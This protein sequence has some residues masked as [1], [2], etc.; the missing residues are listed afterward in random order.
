MLSH[1]SRTRTAVCR[2]VRPRCHYS[3]LQK[4][5]RN[6]FLNSIHVKTF[7]DKEINDAFDKLKTSDEV[8]VTADIDKA[9]NEHTKSE[10]TREEIHLLS[11]KVMEDLEAK[12]KS[13]VVTRDSFGTGLRRLGSRFDSRVKPLVA[14]Y[15]V[16]GTTIGVIVPCMPLLVSELNISSPQ[17]GVIV[18]SFGL[19]KLLGNIPSSHYVD[20]VGRKPLFFSGLVLASFAIGGIGLS[21]NPL[22]GYPWIICCRVLTGLGVSAI[23]AGG[24]MMVADIST[25]LNRTQ[26]QAPLQSAWQMGM[27]AGPGVGGFLIDSFGLS[28]TY[29]SVG[30]SML[31]VTAVSQLFVQET[32]PYVFGKDKQKALPS[33]P[34][35]VPKEQLSNSVQTAL[36]SWA[37]LMRGNQELKHVVLLNGS[38]WA[39][40]SGVQLTMLPLL[41]INPAL[42]MSASQIGFTFISLSLVSLATAQP[43]AYL[44]DNYNKHY[45]FVAGC[46]L[47]GGSS[48]FVPF[49]TSAEQLAMLMVPFAIGS[50]VMQNVPNAH[51]INICAPKDAPQAMSLLRTVGDIGL[52]AGA[53]TSGLLASYSSV[54]TVIQ[55]QGSILFA[56]LA[57]IGYQKYM[58]SSARK[59]L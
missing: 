11:S 17:F 43:L 13:G 23:M 41:M 49:A 22:F 29:Y 33:A 8:I 45:M 48:V 16:T 53:T 10:L 40:M 32:K 18:S 58:S 14:C 15:L 24:N 30:G 31:L 55:G 25:F 6:A 54:E 26:T 59:M 50:T 38:Y 34:A 28:A 47:L 27:I 2:A 35:D 46:A 56:T 42:D 52:I 36:S 20:I 37:R 44:A 3:A 9:I 19:A 7:T 5:D 21:L 1:W 12:K 39:V 4:Y 51:V 57:Y